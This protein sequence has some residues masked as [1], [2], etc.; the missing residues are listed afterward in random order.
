MKKLLIISQTTA[1]AENGIFKTKETLAVHYE[2][3]ATEW[4]VS[5][6]LPIQ[7]Q[8][9][10]FHTGVCAPE[11]IRVVSLPRKLFSQIRTFWHE[12]SHADA[13]FVFMPTWRGVLGGLITA[14]LRKPLAIYE[15][16]A[17]DQ[18]LETQS[19]SQTGFRKLRG[20][21]LSRLARH[22]ENL[23]FRCADCALVTGE[24]LQKRFLPYNANTIM[25]KPI[26]LLEENK[27][28]VRTDYK[29]HTPLQLLTVGNLSFAK[30]LDTL[31][32]ATAKVRKKQ[33]VHLTCVGAGNDLAALQKIVQESH[34]EDCVFFPGYE[35][36]IQ[37]LAQ[38]Y[39]N[40]DFFILASL[41]E[42][43]PRVL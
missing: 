26:L 34:L 7:K 10:K 23:L 40:A 6:L 42:G 12:C 25:T 4:N 31:I 13:V 41:S 33:P 35:N 37:K 17:W 19:H 20:R 39:R 22:M 14:L 18:F 43:M 21:I 28:E 11:K 24:E 9:E 36:D 30:G 29:L 1:G 32:R 27:T 5:L 16:G 38:F 8:Y 15:G 2:K 3:L